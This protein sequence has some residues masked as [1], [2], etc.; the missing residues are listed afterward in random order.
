[1]MGEAAL[2]FSNRWMSADDKNVIQIRAY[3]GVY[4]TGCMR[5]ECGIFVDTLHPFV[6]LL[7]FADVPCV[8]PVRVSFH[9]VLSTRS[10]RRLETMAGSKR[11]VSRRLLG[12]LFLGIASLLL[13]ILSENNVCHGM[14]TPDEESFSREVSAFLVF[15][16][17]DDM[18]GQR[19]TIAPRPP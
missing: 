18:T 7:V 12:I 17:A 16:A 9:Q 15:A 4:K 19:N 13:G 3:P 5:G 8:I 2:C 1:M 11:S 6:W 10:P 14:P